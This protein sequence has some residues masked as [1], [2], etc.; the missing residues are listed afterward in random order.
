MSNISIP[1]PLRLLLFVVLLAGCTLLGW[2]AFQF[3][4]GD[5]VMTF[6]QRNP[7]LAPEAQLAG[8]DAAVAYAPRDPLLHLRRGGVY[9][10]AANEDLSEERLATALNELRT[11]T[12]LSPE[13]Y[14]NWLALGRALDRSGE[15]QDARAA[16][17]RAVRLAPQHFEP[18][19]ALGNHLLRVGERDASFAQMRLALRTRPSALPL[20]L[21]YAWNVYQGDGRAI[22][23]ALDPPAELQMPLVV[24]L[25]VRGRVEDGIAVWRAVK[26]P[27]SADAQKVAEAL[28]FAGRYA[29]AYDVWNAAALP[30]RP[31]PDAGSLLSNGGFERKLA[32][33]D[34]TPFLTWRVTP[35]TG[36]RITLD[37]Q[38]PHS[39]EQTL[40]ASFDLGGNTPF[41]IATQ[42]VRVNPSTNYVLSFAVRSEELQSLSTPLVEVY[43][44]A[45]EIAG[46]NRVRAAIPQLPVG[47]QAWTEHKLAFT[48]NSATEAVTVRVRRPPCSEPP[49]P[50]SGRIWLDEFRL[51]SGTGV[52]AR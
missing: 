11:A 27:S 39:G 41:N 23:A 15:N 33:N 6:V 14:R 34:A 32:L 25:I 43:D 28:F 12:R 47:T 37:R 52:S 3:A 22:A 49:C 1:L 35:M 24:Q 8:A 4:A 50:I 46:G 51:V 2:F 18:H 26:Q 38:T 17:E 30:D 7:N 31:T 44:A 13:D 20:V 40:R 21:D 48:T 42:T 45:F 10:N 9:L 29:Q 16:L 19:W 5:S 36:V